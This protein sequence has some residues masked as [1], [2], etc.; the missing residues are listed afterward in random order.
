MQRRPPWA[1][2]RDHDTD[3][4]AEADIGEAQAVPAKTQDEALNAS[5]KAG[6]NEGRSRE[7]IL[8][9]RGPSSTPS[10]SSGGEATG[11]RAQRTLDQDAW[12]FCL[13]LLRPDWDTNALR[14]LEWQRSLRRR[15]R[16]HELGCPFWR[17]LIYDV[18]LWLYIEIELFARTLA[19]RTWQP[20]LLQAWQRDL[21]QKTWRF[22]FP[23]R[24]HYD[25]VHRL[26][27][28]QA[29]QSNGRLNTSKPSLA[30]RHH[31]RAA[32]KAS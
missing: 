32:S 16:R 25:M 23:T 18:N 15:C 13:A 24:A 5:S 26:R 10:S 2:A 7:A 20:W 9:K 31:K 21:R 17:V 12:N 1:D 30:Q 6:R 19:S 22:Y 4:D 11:A 27:I 29:A 3:T 28:R 8:Q 14:L